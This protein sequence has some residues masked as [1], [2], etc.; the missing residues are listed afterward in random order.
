MSQD[1]NNNERQASVSRNPTATGKR[2]NLQPAS[3]LIIIR[4]GVIFS[5]F[6]DVQHAPQA[7]PV[8]SLKSYENCP[9]VN[10]VGGK[11][12]QSDCLACTSNCV[13]LPNEE[14]ELEVDEVNNNCRYIVC[15]WADARALC[16]YTVSDCTVCLLSRR[17]PM[18]DFNWMYTNLVF[19]FKTHSGNYISSSSLSPVSLPNEHFELE[20]DQANNCRYADTLTVHLVLCICVGI[21]SLAFRFK[22]RSGKYISSSSLSPVFVFTPDQMTR[23]SKLTSLHAIAWH[24]VIQHKA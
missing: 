24:I 5:L 21:L 12:S 14:F 23:V 18:K 19:R 20:V 9:E 6:V 22:T 16:G 2:V 13:V 10:V 15:F 17:G 4:T 3:T 1:N 11:Y 7:N 8:D